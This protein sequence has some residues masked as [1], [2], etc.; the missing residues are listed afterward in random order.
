MENV[1]DLDQTP[2]LID[3]S[4]TAATEVK[5]VLPA[6]KEMTSVSPQK[7]SSYA[8]SITKYWFWCMRIFRDCQSLADYTGWTGKYYQEFNRG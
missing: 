2:P 1:S 3:K 8:R 6:D 5:S 7:L 4:F